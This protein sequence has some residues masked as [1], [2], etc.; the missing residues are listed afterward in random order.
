MVAAAVLAA[1]AGAAAYRLR[2]AS[3]TGAAPPP[4]A[5]TASTAPASAPPA[6]PRSTPPSLGPAP[7]VPPLSAKPAPSSPAPAGGGGSCALPAYPTPACTGVP[8]GWTPRKT[9]DGDLKITKAGTVIEDHLVTGSITVQ[10]DNVTIRNTRVYGKVDNFIGDRIYGP[11]TM[12]G[13]EAVNPPGQEFTT[14]GEYAIGTASFT[15]RRCK[16]VNRIEGFRAGGS[17]SANFGPILIEDSFVQLAVP[18]GLCA[19][20]DPHGDGIQGYGGPP[21][22]L[23]HNT[24]DQRLDDCPTAPV[25]IPAGQGNNGGAIDDNLLAGGGYSLRL[26][27]GPFTSVT[28]NKIVQGT[29]AYGPV[30]VTCGEIDEWSGNALVTYDWAT[31][32]IKKEVKKITECG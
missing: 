5:P 11:L 21:I 8:A 2:P 23:R 9:V 28:G 6:S 25:F 13:L 27:G 31:G 29:P 30:E 16:I 10:A 14:S 22:T 18:P 15:C 3:S 17:G 4:T 12:I 1:S 19:S 32:R 7:A 24:I 26:T 20:E